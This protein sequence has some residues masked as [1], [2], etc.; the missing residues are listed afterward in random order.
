MGWLLVV[1]LVGL[2]LLG[3]WYFGKI[4][5]QPL[6]LTAAALLAGLAAYAFWGSPDKPGSPKQSAAAEGVAA[7]PIPVSVTDKQD[8]ADFLQSMDQLIR[9]GQTKEAA[10]RIRGRIAKEPKDPDLWV[11][12][13]MALST[14]SGGSMPAAAEASFQRAAEI[15]PDGGGFIIF[16]GLCLRQ[17]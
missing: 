5:R 2:V 10:D 6:E 8:T 11:T 16:P 1:N 7:V 12:L 14:H 15:A 3:L 4:G 17:A 13:G 9:S